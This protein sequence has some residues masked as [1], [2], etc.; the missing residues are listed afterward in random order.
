MLERQ[1][2]IK[3]GEKMTHPATSTTTTTL[4]L[5]PPPSLS[6][7]SVRGRRGWGGEKGGEITHSDDFR[8]L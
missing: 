8:L 4:P 2:L 7:L 3:W 6:L 1:H 5:N